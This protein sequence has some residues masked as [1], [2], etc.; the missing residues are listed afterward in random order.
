MVRRRDGYRC[1]ECGIPS[2]QWTGR[3]SGCGAW[4]SLESAP[5][6]V[7]A[8]GR[9]GEASAAWPV[10]LDDIPLSREQQLGSG[11]EELDR[12]L[13]GGLVP[14]SVTLLG[15]DP[16]I[17]K[18]TLVLQMLAGVMSAGHSALMVS[19]EEAPAQV[20][21][22]ADRLGTPGNLWVTEEPDVR[23]IEVMVKRLRPAVV[24]VDSVQTVFD[25][26]VAAPPGSVAQ[27]R[28]CAQHLSTVARSSGAAVVVVGHVT[29]DGVLAG[30]RTLEHLVDTVLSF[31]GDRHHSLRLLRALK[32]RFGVTGEL[33]IFEMTAAG[34]AAV[35]DASALMLAERRVDTA[36]VVVVPALEGRRPLLVELQALA[37]TSAS[38]SP[39]RS[40][41]GLDGG[42]LAMLLAAVE[43]HVGL[44]MSV[45]EVFASAVGGVRVIEPAVDLAVCLAVVSAVSG[46]AVPRDLVA[47]G[48]VGL[49]GEIRGVSQAGKRHGETSRLGFKRAVVPSS[50]PE[51]D[52]LELIRVSSISEAVDALSL[53]GQ[54]TVSGSEPRFAGRQST[55]RSEGW[56]R[57]R[58]VGRPGARAGSH[59]PISA[60]GSRT[61]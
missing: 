1:T 48:E 33:G 5:S 39:R 37:N 4:N 25:S 46:V 47:Y 50:V 27:V 58:S 11:M 19:A 57:R 43:R 23:A 24:A 12:V 55:V 38:V 44:N 51:D 6:T 15:G 32:H 3:C 18:S 61:A 22:R 36:G 34:L 60:R 31:E 16:G 2:A 8:D 10:T 42:R 53:L 30:P 28:A 49:S 35:R 29:K 54:P 14:G 13:S 40:A 59:R 26:D 20:R 7:G 56:Q 41:Q 45:L 21:L 52:R 17:G 9:S